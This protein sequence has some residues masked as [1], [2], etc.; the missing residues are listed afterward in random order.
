MK[1]FA[2][3]GALLCVLAAIVAP[4][5]AQDTTVQIG[6]LWGSIRPVI[7]DLIGI[8]VLGVLGWISK[9][10]HDRFGIEIEAKHREALQTAAV[11]GINM[12]LGRF[13]PKIE[14]L[15]IDVKNKLI[16]DAMSYMIKAVP[17]AITYFK[18]DQKTDVLRDLLKAKLTVALPGPNA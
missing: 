14:N 5:F 10:I 9:I 18:L 15:S 4:A 7:V 12:A 16:A 3:A 17:D 13:D 11:N 2:L 1:L 8:V 6:G